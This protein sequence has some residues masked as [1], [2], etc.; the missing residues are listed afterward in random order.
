MGNCISEMKYSIYDRWGE[1]VF[2]T[3]DQTE[4]WDGTFRGKELNSG[5]YAYKFNATLVDGSFVEQSGNL[6]LVR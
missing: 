2:E 1:K 6:T 5:V 4:C 3:E